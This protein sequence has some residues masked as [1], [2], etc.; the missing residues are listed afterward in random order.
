MIKKISY[1]LALLALC[2]SCSFQFDAE[3]MMQAPKPPILI[4]QLK[5]YVQ[6]AERAAKK[7]GVG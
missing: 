6:S 5:R 4:E 2:A 3:R 7:A 1:I